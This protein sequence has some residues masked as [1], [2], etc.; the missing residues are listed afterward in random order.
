MDPVEAALASFGLMLRSCNLEES[1]CLLVLSCLFSFFRSGT[2][3]TRKEKVSFFG[4]GVPNLDLRFNPKM[5]TKH[6]TAN[7]ELAAFLKEDQ[8]TGFENEIQLSIGGLQ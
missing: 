7:V 1:S 8:G 6:R 2:G 5:L 3:R 4:I